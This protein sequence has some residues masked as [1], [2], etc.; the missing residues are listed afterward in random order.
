M[1]NFYQILFCDKYR[2]RVFLNQSNTDLVRKF[3]EI[4]RDPKIFKKFIL[5]VE[6]VKVN[7]YNRT[8]Y[9]FESKLP[10]GEVYAIKVDSHRFYTLQITNDRYREL[11]ICRYGKK[12]SQKNDKQLT[13][14][15]DSIKKIEIQKVELL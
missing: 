9:N 1:E 7:N 3:N 12:E 15:I 5:V 6:S 4:N 2:F 10:L 11:Y 8:Q 13:T 14:T